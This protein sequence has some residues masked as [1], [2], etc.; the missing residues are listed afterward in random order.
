[1]KVILTQD[2][3]KQGKKGQIIEV[4]EGYGRNFLI[5]NNLAIFADNAA[6]NQLKSKQKAEARNAEEILEEAKQTKSQLEEKNVVVIIEVKTGDDGRLFGTIPPKQIAD[7][8]E[9]QFEIS[10]DRRKIQLGE[11]ISA[12]GSYN[13]PI[14]LHHEVTADIAVKVVGI[15]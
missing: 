15:K 5:K 8:L 13:V 12:L 1:M 9:K 3:K 4:S 11:N 10:V 2:V 6:L 7:E 14:K